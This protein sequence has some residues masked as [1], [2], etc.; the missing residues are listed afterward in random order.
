MCREEGEG[1][2][3]RF[4]HLQPGLG[5]PWPLKQLLKSNSILRLNKRTVS[6]S[7]MGDSITW[8][9][10]LKQPLTSASL[11]TRVVIGKLQH[12]APMPATAAG[13]QT[14]LLDGCFLGD[15]V[16]RGKLQHVASMPGL[17]FD[18]SPCRVN[19]YKLWGPLQRV[20]R[21]EE[22]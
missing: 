5:F 14:R 11:V 6:N 10:Y 20:H 1:G 8:L 21:P 3:L 2:D 17:S 9:V 4:F 22:V 13:I 12:S 19:W 15:R 18:S 16:V 7:N